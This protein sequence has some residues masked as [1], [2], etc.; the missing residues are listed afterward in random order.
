MSSSPQLI[1]QNSI[2]PTY[3]EQTTG[4]DRDPIDKYYTK[5]SVAQEC[6]SLMKKHASP[7]KL[8]DVIIEPSAGNGAFLLPLKTLKCPVR[9]YDIRPDH[10]QVLERDY[11]TMPAE[12]MVAGR[13]PEGKIHVVGNPPFGRQASLAIKFI[14]KTC[15]FADSISFILPKSFKKDSMRRAFSTHF[16]LVH[17]HDLSESS[18]LVNNKDHDSPCVFQVW[19]RR[20]DPRPEPIVHTP[21]HFFFVKRP[22]LVAPVEGKPPVIPHAAIRR[23]GVY[24]G[25]VMRTATAEEAETKSDQT[26]YFIRFL[27]EAGEEKDIDSIVACISD[28]VYDT[29]NTVGPRSISKNELIGAVNARLT[30]REQKG[31]PRINPTVCDC[32]IL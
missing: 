23:V 22:D 11:L 13:A 1:E 29:D 7:R 8:C 9:M 5:T 15:T 3:M 17:Q 4:L 19:I 18:F 20:A 24:A 6:V 31:S 30:T 2:V 10:P 28:I 25:K 26:H 21:V 27:P 32:P 16:H 14:K 12:E